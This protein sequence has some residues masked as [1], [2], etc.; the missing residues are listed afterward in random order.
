MADIIQE[1]FI[2]PP[3]VVARLGGGS[4]PQDS[5]RWAESPNPRSSAQTVVVP[6]WSL[7][8]E[9]DGSVSPRMPRSLRFRD[10]GLIRPVAPFFEV[11]ARVGASGSSAATWRDVPVTP[12]LLT[13]QGVALADVRFRITAINGKAARRTGNAA[14]RFG[15]FPPMEVRADNN[16]RVPLLASSPP[17]IARPMI[18]PTRNIPLGSVQVIRSRPQPASGATP[19]ADKVNVEVLRM[20]FTP[21]RGHVYG[22]PAS[23]GAQPTPRGATAVPVDSNRAFLDARA[24]WANARFNPPDAPGDTYD[25]SDV[26]DNRSLGVVDDTCEARIEVSFAL[27]RQAARVVSAASTV[28]VAPPDFAPDRRPFLSLADELNDRAADSAARNAAV[29]GA[30]RDAWVEDLF[31]RIQETVALLNVDFWRRARAATLSGAQLTTPIAGDATPNAADAMGGRDALRNRLFPLA[32]PVAPAVLPMTEHARM[33]HR[34]MADLQELRSFIR[35]NPGRLRALVRSP[36][37]LRPNEDAL[38]TTMAMPPFMRNS[39]AL[40]L[41]LSGWQ[42]DLLMQWVVDT[43]AGSGPIGVEAATEAVRAGRAVEPPV[44]VLSEAAAQR[45]DQVLERVRAGGL[46]P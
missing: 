12:A 29:V 44:R 36:F 13:A 40:P 26:A 42:Y 31:E 20:R 39:N 16:R 34:A 6:D 11:W 8:V 46:M 4:V 5:Y 17:G 9:A 24:G 15:T 7:T 30:D 28:F 23:A 43:E 3:L 33:R 2:N 27:P 41:T 19:W 18:P 1:V 35:Q 25:G 38:G 22:P 21:A 32:A 37:G 45:R 10:G 14:L